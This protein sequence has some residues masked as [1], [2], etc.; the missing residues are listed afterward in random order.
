[1]KNKPKLAARLDPQLKRFE[2]PTVPAAKRVEGSGTSEKHEN[3]IRNLF[4]GL[5][6]IRRSCR[7]GTGS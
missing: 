3:D 4:C 5:K 1:M 6:E 2:V 7:K